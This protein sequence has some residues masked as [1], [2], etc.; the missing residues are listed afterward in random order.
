MKPM[1]DKEGESIKME[2]EERFISMLR[3]QTSL[4]SF[5]SWLYENYEV[6][7]KFVDKDSYFK[8]LDLNYKSK[9]VIEDLET[10]LVKVLGY[11]SVEDFKIRDL[12]YRLVL[13]TEDDE[14][15]SVC[16]RIYDEY[17]NGYNFFRLI[18]LKYIVWD[19]DYQLRDFEARTEFLS[20][21]RDEFINE[22]RRLISYFELGLIQ[23]AGEREYSD[24]RSKND[25]IEED[26]WK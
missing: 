25:K 26:Y 18:A 19:Y 4:L 3:G 8:L 13:V 1:Q 14:F 17:C 20:E 23:I 2:Y 10:L 16:R 5:E 22:G 11:N 24:R 6:L 7:E 15:I 12:L 21:Y 9:Y